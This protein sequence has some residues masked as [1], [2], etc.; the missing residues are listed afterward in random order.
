MSYELWPLSTDELVLE[1]ECESIWGRW[2][3]PYDRG[4][5]G[6]ETHPA[7]PADRER[8]EFLVSSLREARSPAGRTILRA[9]PEFVRIRGTGQR[10]D[11]FRVRW[12]PVTVP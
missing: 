12:F 6:L 10:A 5:I 8:R 3:D 1:I 11:D 2:L 4:E 9:R 7:L